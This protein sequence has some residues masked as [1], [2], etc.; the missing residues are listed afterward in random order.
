MKILLGKKLRLVIF[1]LLLIAILGFLVS[2]PNNTK[3]D[4]SMLTTEST[5][6]LHLTSV[7]KLINKD[8][9]KD[10]LKDWEE[11]LWSTDLNNPD[12]DGDGTNDGDEV[13]DNRNPNL[14]GPDDE[15]NQGFVLQKKENNNENFEE[16]L[17]ATDLFSQNLFGEYLSLRGSGQHISD[18]AKSS[19]VTSVIEDTLDTEINK[20]YKISDLNIVEDNS[21]V[22]LKKYGNDF[23]SITQLYS[24]DLTEDEVDVFERMLRT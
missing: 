4:T 16:D 8:S 22:A 17:T 20:Q 13:D 10:G 2:Q 14:P 6:A 24:Q 18:T 21:A 23:I 11:G 5:S 12:T 19:L 1:G 3:Y 15:L 9:D 7:S